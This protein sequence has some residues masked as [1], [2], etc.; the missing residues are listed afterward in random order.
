MM[1]HAIIFAN[2]ELKYPEALYEIAASA[3]V[4]IAAD[5]GLSH[6]ENLKLVPNLL[7]GDLDSVTYE[8]VKN[9]IDS[10]C[11]VRRYVVD[12]DETDLELALLA[13]ADMNCNK[14]T[15]TTALGGRLDQT[16]SNIYLLNL[17]QLAQLDVRIDDGKEEIF[18]IHNQVKVSGTPGDTL[19]LLPLTPIVKGINTTGLKY[20]LVEDELTFDHSR[21]I[22]NVMQSWNA[23][24]EIKSGILLCIHIR[25]EVLI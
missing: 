21:G 20:P 4:I 25:S 9:T 22:S 7:I 8:Q 1:K 15:I 16:L 13:A 6:I 3:D 23:R 5:G 24:V 18:L 12:K 10:G 11:T 17:P 2:G 14:I 19:S